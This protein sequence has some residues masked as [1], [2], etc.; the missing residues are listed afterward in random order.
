MIG[1]E[2][3]EPETL[4]AVVRG[5]FDDIDATVVDWEAA[6]LAYD[7]RNPVSGGLLRVRGTAVNAGTEKNWSLIVKGV[8]PAEDVEL[9]PGTKGIRHD[10]ARPEGFS[11][12]EREGLAY[13]SGVLADL[14][15]GLSAPR[16]LSVI[17]LGPTLFQL[18]LEE[19][20]DAQPPVWDN[21]DYRRAAR[22]LGHFNGAYLTGRPLPDQPWLAY[23]WL[24]SW[25]EQVAHRFDTDA[26]PLLEAALPHSAYRDAFGPDILERFASLVEDGPHI[27]AALERLPRVLCHRDAF[28]AN[29]FLRAESDQ[30]VAID[31]ACVGIGV[32]GEELAPL[33]TQRFA[34]RDF[35]ELEA[36]VMPSYLEGLAGAG[37]EPSEDLV[38]FG[39]AATAALRYL[40][41]SIC[42]PAIYVL[43][44]EGGDELEGRRGTSV[45][46]FVREEADVTRYLLGLLE[47]ARRLL[48]RL[49]T[50]S[51]W[52]DH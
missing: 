18:W 27:L 13:H 11:N 3:I 47:E 31:W 29:L 5:L 4:S 38:R 26:R 20:R 21:A 8:R 50:T 16:C 25:F 24:P 40:P 17:E 41:L 43:N 19:I 44:P 10:R 36:V 22:Q 2:S 30:V 7:T 15:P 9:A 28:P 42:L 12:W 39:Y 49:L 37:W 23:G 52:T 51:I 45:E 6:P 35:G 1:G 48:T 14:P 33:V 32:V 34:G 46:Q